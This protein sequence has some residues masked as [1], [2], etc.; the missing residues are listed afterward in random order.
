VVQD[1]DWASDTSDAGSIPELVMMSD[2][3]A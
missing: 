1:L 3:A 2:E